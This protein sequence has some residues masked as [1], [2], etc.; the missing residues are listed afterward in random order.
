MSTS[1]TDSFLQLAKEHSK[2]VKETH[3]AAI[4]NRTKTGLNPSIESRKAIGIELEME[5]LSA[6]AFPSLQNIRR[7]VRGSFSKTTW[8]AVPDHSLRGNSMEY[9]LDGVC[10]REE[11]PELV[12][13][14]FRCLTGNGTVLS[15]SNRC[16]THV[17]LNVGSWKLHELTSFYVFWAIFEEALIRWNGLERMNNH[18]CL[19]I[20]SS[21]TTLALW[22]K[23]IRN[24]Q[25]SGQR[26]GAKYSAFNFLPLF[27]T[28]SVEIRCGKAP[29]NQEEIITW[30]I[31]LDVMKE[32]V[33]DN[34]PDPRDFAPLVSEQGFVY[35]LQ[36]MLDSGRDYFNPEYIFEK[37]VGNLTLDQ[38]EKECL[39]G[40]RR[41]Q[42]LCFTLPWEFWINEAAGPVVPNPF[43]VE[44]SNPDVEFDRV[45]QRLRR[46]GV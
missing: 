45:M 43:Q 16:S 4:N 15:N 28:G 3:F 31:L 18:F 39:E 8:N 25:F 23:F 22:E 46:F 40:F 42:H 20:K 36:Q 11:V 19:S 29:D 32:F 14:L 37:I 38:F 34:Y 44:V 35:L 2:R 10:L 1:A 41:V 7:K 26:G 9:V 33:K 6:T 5:A 30:V 24:G 21:P 13:G 17:H 27:E 12:A